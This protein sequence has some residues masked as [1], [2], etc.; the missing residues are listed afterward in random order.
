MSKG[1]VMTFIEREK[2]DRLAYYMN[3][4]KRFYSYCRNFNKF[5]L[6]NEEVSNELIEKYKN[7]HNKV[8]INTYMDLLIQI[9]KNALDKI[10]NT[11][12]AMIIL[13]NSIDPD[14]EIYTM[15]DQACTK[16]E[17]KELM[18]DRFNFYDPDLIKA[19][20]KYIQEN[21]LEKEY[22]WTYKK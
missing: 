19:E 3:I 6:T 14:Y 5:E 13:I 2:R 1:D 10:I 9:Q 20:I 8:D 12:D 16:N 7:M 4:K 21:H 17:L 18:K 15:Y 11:T 22:S